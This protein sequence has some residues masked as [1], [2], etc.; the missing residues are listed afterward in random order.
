M[1]NIIFS[2]IVPYK[3]R[4]GFVKDAISSVLN[5]E[6]IEKKCIEILAIGDPTREKKTQ[7]KLKKIFPSISYLNN[8][9]KEGPGGK[10]NTGLKRAKGKYIVFL[11]SDD[12]LKRNFLIVMQKALERTK[13][14]GGVICLSDKLFEKRFPFKEQLL[15]LP[16]SCIQDL[17]IWLGCVFNNG[18][19]FKDSF[20]LSQLSHMMFKKSAIGQIKFNYDYRKGG[21][22]W[23]FCFRILKKSN[24]DIVMKRLII[25]RYSWGS[26]TYTP[27]IIKLKWTS[28]SLLA[29][30]L[31][32]KTKNSI[33]Y[34]LFKVYIG[35][36][37]NK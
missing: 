31:P 17:G 12:Q 20:Y 22:D 26:S 11:D 14:A 18:K 21:E 37:G 2:V 1:N 10:R 3:G 29:S 6:G 4:F 15:R 16:L 27:E 13:N 23:D 5:Q 7:K 35:I 9:D 8:E 30:K 25:F 19:L 36:F 34:K 24:L 33:F 32:A 28:Y